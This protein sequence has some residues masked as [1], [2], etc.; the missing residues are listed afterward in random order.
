M[1]FPTLT[2]TP[3]G[4]ECRKLY[5]GSQT[6]WKFAF[7]REES[8]TTCG[9]PAEAAQTTEELEPTIAQ[10]RRARDWSEPKKRDPDGV[11]NEEAT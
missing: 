8:R 7:V 3:F 4:E 1:I 6:L 9:A 5:A 11:E 10:S 2:V